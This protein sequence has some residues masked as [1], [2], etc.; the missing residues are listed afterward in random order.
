LL[1]TITA[2]AALLRFYK[3]GV[4]PPGF[5]FD[6]AFNAI[7]AAQVLHGNFPLFLP[8]N[9]GREV[10]YTYL[11]A[12][13]GALL[14]I[15]VYTLRLASALLGIG[16]VAA[17]FVLL[18]QILQ[19][20]SREI[21]T[22]TSLTLALSVW[23]LHFSHYGIRV[24][25]MPL[26]FSGLFGCYWWA[27]HAATRR[28]RL[29][30]FLLAGVLTGLSVYT[31]PTGRFVPFV[32]IAYTAWLLWWHPQ[33]RRWAWDRPLGG[34]LLTGGVA[35]IVFLPLGLEFY[36]HPAWFTG[37]ASEVSVF[38]ERV[39]DGQP[40]RLLLGNLLRVLGMFSFVGHQEWAHGPIERPVFDWLM[41]IPFTLGILL[42]GARLVRR[43]ADDP[44]VDALALLALWASVMLLPSVLSEAAPNFSRTLP[45][46]PAIFVG[47]GLGLAWLGQ[48]TPHTQQQMTTGRAAAF[49][50]NPV[51]D[52]EPSNL[53]TPST[54]SPFPARE[55][56]QGVRSLLPLLIIAISGFSAFYDYFVRFPSLPQVYF[57]YEANKLDALALLN[58]QAATY[59]V[60][61]QPLW[62]EHPPVRALRSS[63]LIKSLDTA[64]ALV[65]P[66]VGHGVIYAYPPEML[67]QAE[68][69]AALWP[70]AT[71]EQ[72]PDPY[73]GVLYAQVKLSAEQVA[74]WP[75][76]HQP[77]SR[78]VARFADGPTLLGMQT[79]PGSHEVTLFWQG[80][81]RAVVR[82]LTAFVHLIDADG[83]RVGQ[84]D[85]VPG[86][87]S[88][89]TNVW[90]PGERV[91]EHY[92]PEIT[93]PCVG[94]E[95]VQVQ[96]GWYELAA[97]GARRPRT[98]GPG[99]LAVA[100]TMTLPMRGYAAGQLTPP[101]PSGQSLGAGQTLLG[102]GWQSAALEAGAPL[103]VDL[104]LHVEPEQAQRPLTLTL[105][106]DEG[107]TRLWQSELAPAGTW[108]ADEWICRRVRT[109]VPLDLPPGDYALHVA[110]DA[111][112]V[113][114]EELT[115]AASSRTFNLP[116]VQQRVEAR[117][118]DALQLY[119]YQVDAPPAA[120]T[121]TVTLVWQALATPAQSYTVFVHLL[122]ATGVL[123]A[124]SDAL[125]AGGYA[126]D[127][128]LPGEVVSDTH[129]LR[130]PDG[131]DAGPY[132]LAVGLYDVATGQRLPATD[133]Q[134]QPWPDDAVPLTVTG[135]P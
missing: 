120:S 6:E 87:G 57:A 64:R 106:D 41:S 76:A 121:V 32:L 19:R 128:W 99:D 2:L 45:A 92:L 60:F 58:Q 46:L 78:V 5:Q 20:Q 119:G 114:L 90:S 63:K 133:Q 30:A 98:D 86:N 77:T 18:R 10:L 51:N 7:D 61:L 21:A 49:A 31:N 39:S 38:A 14:G 27:T 93:E 53:T 69:L 97:G 127:R 129:T 85:Q 43:R 118:G 66:P 95:P 111:A 15:N 82:A 131:A 34:L 8:A 28:R 9:G 4:V 24:I 126:T 113:R 26:L 91:I 33:A 59:E 101:V 62:A 83:Q 23:H 80:E 40:W 107:N 68:A 117:L 130:L 103:L 132:R 56:G 104:Y 88:Y 1:L 13:I 110:T 94:G 81:E 16:A 72:I 29:S 54:G 122:D 124:Q 100:G 73:G 125:P 89:P 17:T 84:S 36:Q 75:P 134:G 102:Y 116:P 37:H 109:A 123:V 42:W 96:V 52:G 65:L 55:G 35:F 44:D 105:T 67:G 135:M 12:G 3:L 11:Q 112:P 48:P 79:Y 115:L 25:T 22:F 71:V 50:S 70:R 74:S 108:Q 47:A